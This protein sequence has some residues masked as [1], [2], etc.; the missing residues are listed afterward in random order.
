MNTLR[1]LRGR[2]QASGADL[3]ILAKLSYALVRSRT[4]QLAA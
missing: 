2:I 3:T 4:V 1:R